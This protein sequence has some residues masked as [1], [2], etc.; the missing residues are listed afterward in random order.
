MLGSDFNCIITSELANKRA[1]KALITCVVYTKHI[2]LFQKIVGKNNVC[3]C[4]TRGEIEHV[5]ILGHFV[6]PAWEFVGVLDG[7][8]FG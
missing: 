8:T 6:V 1:P 5:M 3:N 7:L 4:N 2:H